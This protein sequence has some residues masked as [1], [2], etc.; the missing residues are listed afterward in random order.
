MNQLQEFKF[1]GRVLTPEESKRLIDLV[2]FANNGN[3]QDLAQ[4]SEIN[5]TLLAQIM[6]KRIGAFKM[7]FAISNLCFVMS[8]LTFMDRPAVAIILLWIIKCFCHKQSKPDGYLVTIEDWCSHLFPMGVPTPEELMKWW[9]GQKIIP[10]SGSMN[11][12][13]ADVMEAWTC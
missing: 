7:P 10:D 11:D 3:E 6:L 4:D 13:A 8:L 2:M 5:K 1:K 9:D 12:N